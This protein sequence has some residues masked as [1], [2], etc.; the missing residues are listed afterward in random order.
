[1]AQGHRKRSAATR[2][3]TG[4]TQHISTSRW[5]GFSEGGAW[6]VAGNRPLSRRIEGVWRMAKHRFR[7]ICLALS[8]LSPS[9]Y[10]WQS[11]PPGD[12]GA[13]LWVSQLLGAHAN[14][15][16]KI[17]IGSGDVATVGN[18]AS[19]G[20]LDFTV[21]ADR[22]VIKATATDDTATRRSSPRVRIRTRL[23]STPSRAIE[24]APTAVGNLG[25]PCTHPLRSRGCLQ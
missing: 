5:I 20:P 16:G 1:M 10:R 6:T 15:Q 17:L 24:P 14:G 12:P 7:Q 25:T 22:H 13:F 2:T 19:F 11:L 9:R 23:S 8:Q 18:D 21:P 4:L 3:S